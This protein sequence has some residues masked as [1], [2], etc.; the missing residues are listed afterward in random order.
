MIKK[1]NK[2]KE[3]MK[4]ILKNKIFIFILGGL[5]FGSIGAYAATYFPSSGVTYNNGTSGLAST[6]VQG[7]IDELYNTCFPITA[8]NTILDKEEIVTSG[9]GLYE[10]EYEDRYIFKGTNPNNYI[11]FSGEEWR[12]L[13]IEADGRIKIVRNALDGELVWN[14]SAVNNWIGASLNTYL[15]DVYRN[16]L[17]DKNKIEP[18]RWSIG[19]ITENN[20]DLKDQINDEKSKIWSGDIALITVSEYIRTNSNKVQCGT[21]SLTNDNYSTCKNTTWLYL[22]DNWWTLSP[23]TGSGYVFRLYSDG[24]IDPYFVGNTCGGTYYTH[25][26]RPTLYLNSNVQLTGSGKKSDPYKIV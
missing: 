1:A 14:S 23:W 12:I 9:D 22:N 15:N 5:I 21:F 3:K 19:A 8:G 25:G 4:K 17:S 7:A 16:K 18:S 2:I 10:D 20:N 13:S 24:L 6:N 26:L 11:T